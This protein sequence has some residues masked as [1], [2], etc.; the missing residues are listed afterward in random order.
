MEFQFVDI[1]AQFKKDADY[2]NVGAPGPGKSTQY[3]VFVDHLSS[4]YDD[5]YRWSDAGWVES[6]VNADYAW[7]MVDFTNLQQTDCDFT[8]DVSVKMIYNDEYEFAGWVR[9]VNYDYINYGSKG[10]D[11]SRKGLGSVQ[12]NVVVI[13]PEN[14]EPISMM[15]TGTYVF[16]VTLPNYVVEDTKT[17]L[18]MVI[19]V[20]GNE[21]TYNIHK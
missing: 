9:Q 2:H 17:S 13:N 15:Y 18:S 20:D 3:Q 11:V 8:E 21:L 1:F 7:F 6:G 12:P 16:G 4:Y 10:R 5:N 19:T 14:V